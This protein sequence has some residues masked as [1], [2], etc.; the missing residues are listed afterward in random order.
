MQRN[1]KNYM[2]VSLL[3]VALLLCAESVS[4]AQLRIIRTGT[5]SGDVIGEEIVC[6]DICRAEYPEKTVAHL[7][8]EAR[9]WVGVGPATAGQA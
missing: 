1:R 2:C 3:Y 5:G 4:A 8:A 6:G 9:G 7:K